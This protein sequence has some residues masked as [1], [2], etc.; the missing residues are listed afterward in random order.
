MPVLGITG[1]IATGKSTFVRALLKQ[2]PV[3]FFDADSCAHELLEQDAGV[4]ERIQNEFFPREA[5]LKGLS[6]RARLRELVFTHP[7]KRQALEAILHPVIRERWMA[8]ALQAQRDNEWFV[9]DIPLLFETNAES[10][11]DRVIVVA[12]S[13]ANQRARLKL[14][15][16]LSDE[17]AAKVLAAQFDLAHKITKADHLIWNDSTLSCLEG[18]TALLGG[19]LRK[20]Y[21]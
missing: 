1:G 10:Y 20:C 4:R 7:A 18:Q 6:Q 16:G 11:F 2:R 5:P 8:Q 15:R 14:L 9:A 12:C 19:L 17:I 13:G 3:R 21:G